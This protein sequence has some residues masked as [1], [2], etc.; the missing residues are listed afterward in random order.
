VI[1]IYKGV[2]DRWSWIKT[3]MFNFSGLQANGTSYCIVP[4]ENLG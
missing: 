2:T 4:E 1:P 3:S